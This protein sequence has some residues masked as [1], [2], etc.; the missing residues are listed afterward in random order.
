MKKFKF[1][2][3]DVLTFLGRLVS[4]LITTLLTRRQ[5]KNDIS[6]VVQ[7][8]LAEERKQIAASQGVKI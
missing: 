7:E 4:A 1:Q 5:Q 3:S 8:V 2:K 6:E